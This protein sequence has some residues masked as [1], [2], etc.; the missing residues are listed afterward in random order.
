[1]LDRAVAHLLL[2]RHEDAREGE[3]S[4]M[5]AALVNTTSLASIA[6]ELNLSKFIKLS[7]GELQMA[8]PI[9]N[10]F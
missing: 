9:A 2:D 6:K 1:M 10:P 5:R 7:R 4:K 8:V 3:L